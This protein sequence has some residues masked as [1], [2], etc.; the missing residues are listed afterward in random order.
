M[1]ETGKYQTLEISHQVDFG[2]Y[3]KEP[4]SADETTILLPKKEMPK[5]FEIGD[6]IEVYIY[7]DSEDRLI[8]TTK[9]DIPQIGDIDV[10]EV[11][12]VGNIGAFMN[13]GLTKDLFLPYSQQ[14]VKVKTGRKYLV[15][16][17]VD[18]SDRICATTYVGKYLRTDHNYEPGD[19][20]S[21]T[22][23]RI[24]EDLGAIVAIDNKFLAL[25]PFE[26]IENSFKAGDE[27]T[28]YVAR[29]LEDNKIDMS[30]IKAA[31]LQQDDDLKNLRQHE[32]FQEYFSDVWSDFLKSNPQ[33]RV[34][35]IFKDQ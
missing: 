25:L 3:L 19:K 35:Q 26:Q 5:E 8:A 31:Y 34:Q 33:P 23:F 13:W 21:G 24:R 4:N 29:V 9:K 16:I 27:I 10:F 6:K 14:R 17:Y 1:I 22:I 30:L 2:L 32:E 11:V 7:R 20:I 18:K 12:S 28:G 15:N